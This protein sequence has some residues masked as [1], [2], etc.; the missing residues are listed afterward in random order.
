[1]LSGLLLILMGILIYLRPQ[2]VVALVSGFLIASGLTIMMISWRL[3]RMV[4]AG[5]QTGNAWTRFMIRF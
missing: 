5:R 3:R 1:M 2:I 4:Q